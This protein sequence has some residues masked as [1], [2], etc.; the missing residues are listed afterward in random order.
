MRCRG[1]S[2]CIVMTLNELYK[3][4]DYKDNAGM[5]FNADCLDIMAKMNDGAVGFTLTDIP[6]HRN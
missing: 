1:Q 5:M 4:A 2:W 6:F 3:Q